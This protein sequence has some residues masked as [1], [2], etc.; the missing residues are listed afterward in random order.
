MK[1]LCVDDSALIREIVARAAEVLDLDTVEARDGREALDQV[2]RHRDEIRLITLDWHMPGMNGFDFLQAV[3]QHAEYKAIPVLMLTSESAKE[4]IVKA[5]KAGVDNYLLKPFAQE[6]L[7]VK[8]KECMG[9]G[10]G[11]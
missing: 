6:D 8:M 9:L 1:V 10:D 3:K 2:A 4:N 7:L 5:I 11:A